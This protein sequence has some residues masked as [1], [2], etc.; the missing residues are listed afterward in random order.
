MNITARATE[1]NVSLVKT[2]NGH[3]LR[4]FIV[5]RKQTHPIHLHFLTTWIP[6]RRG[7]KR[8]VLPWLLTPLSVFGIQT[9]ASFVKQVK[10]RD[11]FWLEP[12]MPLHH[13]GNRKKSQKVVC[14]SCA[15]LAPFCCQRGAKE[16][17]GG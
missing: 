3:F 5:V 4:D 10:R 15:P 16:S 2:G 9:A 1:M 13:S 6:D 7:K 11:G 8:L 12:G 17:Q 14:M